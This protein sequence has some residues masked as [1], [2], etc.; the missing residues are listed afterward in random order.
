MHKE[1]LPIYKS[2]LYE[3]DYLCEIIKRYHTDDLAYTFFAMSPF[4][5]NN[6][7]DKR[8]FDQSKTYN[9][10]IS[11]AELIN[12]LKKDIMCPIGLTTTNNDPEYAYYN[13]LDDFKTYIDDYIWVYNILSDNFSRDTYHRTIL[14]RLI[15]DYHYI[16]PY[17]KS[18]SYFDW[19][20]MNKK[21]NMVYVDCGAFDGDTVK[22]F[23]NRYGNNYLKIYAYEPTPDSFE[24]LE[25]ACNQYENVILR[26]CGVGNANDTMCFV[27]EERSASSSWGGMNPAVANRFTTDSKNNKTINVPIIKLDDDINESIDFIKMD[28]EGFEEQA[29]D[30]CIN[31]IK[32]DKP[33]LAICVYHD[34]QDLRTI[35]KKIHNM[36]QN[37]T[38]YIRNHCFVDYLATEIV[39]YAVPQ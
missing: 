30:G 10:T 17:Y 34:I 38:F 5:F 8:L 6:D 13:F 29:L 4:L 32:E 36:N 37:Q 33:Q 2:R 14:C 24:L 18:I 19:D 31:H 1:I 12:K 16:L 23:V 39:F 21:S 26:N 3:F 28:V 7:F 35:P 22:D 15:L 25:R 9:I 11:K 27:Q 20:Y